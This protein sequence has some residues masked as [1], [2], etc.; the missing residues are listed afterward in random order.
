MQEFHIYPTEVI[1]STIRTQ[2][3]DNIF[4][5]SQWWLS[6]QST[7]SLQSAHDG[8][9]TTGIH[10]QLD[11][12]RSIH[13]KLPNTAINPLYRHYE[14]PKLFQLVA[15]LHQN[16]G[17]YLSNGTY[18]LFAP[19]EIMFTTTHNGQMLTPTNLS[20]SFLTFFRIPHLPGFPAKQSRWLKYW[21]LTNAAWTKVTVFS[22]E[23]K[24]CEEWY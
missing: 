19:N 13:G 23:L 3:V 7:V 4:S 6:N 12:P 2:T 22:H 14:S 18:M 1:R 10:I 5:T 9:Y 21:T 24:G 16:N 20:C 15:L 8:H 11:N 17:N